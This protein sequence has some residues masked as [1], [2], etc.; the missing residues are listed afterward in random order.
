KL[1]HELRTPLSAIAVA[2]EIMKDE[3]FGKLPNA[4]YRGYASDIYD[5]ARHALAVIARLLSDDAPEA[6]TNLTE[7][8]ELDLN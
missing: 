6:K 8:V 7:T 1:A 5:N 4:R 2:A 3:R